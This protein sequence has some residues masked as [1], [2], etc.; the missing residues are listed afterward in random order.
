MISFKV[1]SKCEPQ[2]SSRALVIGGKVRITS[3]NAKLKPFRHTVTQVAME[4]VGKIGVTPLFGKHVPVKLELVF[5]FRRP[6]SIPKRRVHCVVKPDLDKI[7]RSILDA[8]SGAV[9]RDDAQVVTMSASKIYGDV[10]G[11]WIQAQEIK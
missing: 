2:G 11:V 10:E 1:Y 9:Y 5:T 3:A 7:C 6:P 4:E 8:L